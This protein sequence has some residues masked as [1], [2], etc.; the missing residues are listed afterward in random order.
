MSRTKKGAKGPGY[1]YWS[2][3]PN[4][5]SSPGRISKTITKRKERAENKQAIHRIRKGKDDSQTD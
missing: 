3:R 4:S 1:E 5:V 2:K